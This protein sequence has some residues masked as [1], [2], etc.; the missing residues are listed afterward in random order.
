MFKVGFIGTGVIFDLNLLG[1]LDNKEIEIVSLCNR[2][3]EKAKIKIKRFNLG[4]DINLYSDYREMLKKEELDIV[5]ILL[6][7]HLHAEATISAAKSGVKGISVQKPMALTLEEADLMIEACKEFRSIL[8]IYEN[9]VFS[10]HI[11]KAKEL[12]DQDYIGDP[13]SLRV[14]IAMGGKGGWQIPES[15]KI[16]RKIPKKVGGAQNGSPVL[17]D[18]GWHA[19]VLAQW[20]FSEEIEKVFAW[21]DSYQGMDAPAY[22]MF[23]YKQITEH[24]VPQYGH[25]E[26][27]LMPDLTIPS[28]YYPTDEF[29][30]IIA[31]RGIM[32]IN[33]GT[34]IGNIMTDSEIFPPIS[35]IRDGKVE[36]YRDFDN[37]W[38]FS[39]IN[40]THHFIEA[41]KGNRKPILSGEYA[42]KILKFNLA[43]IKSTELGKEIYL[44]DM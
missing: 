21:T 18:N 4:K 44:D 28:R 19:F 30:E 34:S 31:S 38:K 40:A 36:F 24:V 43:A 16:W 20:L 7:H 42:K 6:P 35:V 37:D 13:S 3:I 32:R 5:E 1:Y 25:M 23:K 15:A 41:V 39:F 26:F 14:K 17:L 10:P 33:Q 9:F 2:T 11:I 22:V 8:S 29:I 27:S 12:I